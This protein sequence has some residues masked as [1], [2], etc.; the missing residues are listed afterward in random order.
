MNKSCFVFHTNP[1]SQHECKS[2]H[3]GIS[4]GM[5]CAG[6]LNIFNSSLLIRGICYTKCLGDGDSKAYQGVVAGKPY[7]P[8][9]AVAKL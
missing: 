5:E 7:D 9:I 1:T 3:E 8:S 6:V 4:G 2:N